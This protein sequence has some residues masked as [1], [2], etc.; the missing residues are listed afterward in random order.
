MGKQ[1][2]E[3]QVQFLKQTFRGNPLQPCRLDAEAERAAWELFH[4]M[5][6][7]AE[8]PHAVGCRALWIK[9]DRGSIEDWMPY[10]RYLREWFEPSVGCR[11]PSQEL[12]K[13]EWEWEFPDPTSW[14]LIEVCRHFDYLL[15][16]FDKESFIGTTP[17]GPS[18]RNEPKVSHILRLLISELKKIAKESAT[19]K[20]TLLLERDLPVQKRMG[21]I[22]RKDLWSVIPTWDNFGK[23]LSHGELE[24]RANLLHAQAPREATPAIPNLTTG[25]YFS[26]LMDA[27]KAAGRTLDQFQIRQEGHSVK[28][29]RTWYRYYGDGR[30]T[31]IFDVD[32]NSASAFKEWYNDD[33]IIKSHNFEV[34][35][36]YR[37]SRCHLYPILEEDGWHLELEGPIPILGSTLYVLWET[38]NAKGL[39]TYLRNADALADAFLGEDDLLVVPEHEQAIHKKGQYGS[40]GVAEAIYLPKG[41]EKEISKFVR[42]FPIEVSELE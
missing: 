21:L 30:E 38:F 17:D 40:Y 29:G 4:T 37:Y 22:K 12:W 34:L 7:F 32:P 16:A 14:H 19:G 3:P 15:I 9:V 35:T 27:Y 18:L 42:W 41:R 33:T 24:Q 11:K 25:K 1:L 23:G 10:E 6:F 20:Y 2:L 13:R 8:L 26:V 28:D 31:T 39:P 36:W 5:E